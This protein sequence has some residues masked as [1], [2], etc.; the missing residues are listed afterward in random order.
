MPIGIIFKHLFKKVVMTKL[1]RALVMFCIW[2]QIMRAKAEEIE[3]AN[4]CVVEVVAHLQPDVQ[5]VITILTH[6]LVQFFTDMVHG[7][8]L[9]NKNLVYFT[10]FKIITIIFF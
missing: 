1:A 5:W 9:K 3:F 10:I 7:D 6:E 8:L 4:V 2:E